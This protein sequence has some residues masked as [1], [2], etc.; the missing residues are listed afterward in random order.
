M[1][2]NFTLADESDADSLVE[3]MR[4]FY[5]VE[6]LPFDERAA[7]LALRQI[8]RERAYGVVHLIRWDEEL[9]GYVVVTFG[10]S[11]EFHGRDALVDELY[12][13]AAYRGRGAG[14]AALRLV[15]AVCREERIES[16]HLEVDR[17]NVTAQE[18][19]R[20]A[21]YA[22]HDRYLLTKWLAEK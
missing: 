22:D 18:L 13:R 10:F 7:R 8:L 11:L 1:N 3:L 5:E 9:I 6:H 21:G 15:E 19:Y 4:E 12:I 20:R 14:R 17:S 2:P 16:V